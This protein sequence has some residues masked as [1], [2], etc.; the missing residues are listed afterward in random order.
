V[1]KRI[2]IEK[3]SISLE[4]NADEF[5]TKELKIQAKINILKRKAKECLEDGK[6]KEAWKILEEATRMN[7][8]LEVRAS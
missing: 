8:Q 7:K 4:R 3:V 1:D 5:R 2:K 6:E